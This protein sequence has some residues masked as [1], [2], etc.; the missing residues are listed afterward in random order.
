LKRR[1][2]LTLLGGAAAAWT[3]AARAQ[4]QAVPVIGFLSSR[5]PESDAPRLSVFRQGL[6][7]LGYVE[8][9]NVA[10]ESASMLAGY[11]PAYVAASGDVLYCSVFKDDVVGPWVARHGMSGSDYQNEF[12]Q[13]VANGFYPICT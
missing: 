1:E 7:D 2:F 11:R 8:G 6:N 12:N 4:H 13:Q 9:Y 10:I 5:S 3:L